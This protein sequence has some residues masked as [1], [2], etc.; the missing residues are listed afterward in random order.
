MDAYKKKTIFDSVITSPHSNKTIEN[1]IHMK[2]L[3]L[4]FQTK[5]GGGKNNAK[6]TNAKR[7]ST[8]KKNELFFCHFSIS[9]CLLFST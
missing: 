2:L 8:N 5:R 1:I 3:L 7:T 9:D 4:L 6:K